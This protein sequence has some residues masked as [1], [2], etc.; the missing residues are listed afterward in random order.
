ML[1]RE[2]RKTGPGRVGAMLAAT[3]AV[4]MI[5]GCSGMNPFYSDNSPLPLPPPLEADADGVVPD[6]TGR[7]DGG[8]GGS[9]DAASETGQADT[10]QNEDYPDLADVPEGDAATRAAEKAPAA[11]AQREELAGELVADREQAKYTDEALRGGK[12]AAMA[13]PRP[14][15]PAPARPAQEA[16]PVTPPPAAPAPAVAPPPVQRTAPR[17]VAPAP[18]A[19]APAA[20]PVATAPVT[21]LAPRAAPVPAAPVQTARAYGSS[22]F[23]PSAAQPLPADLAASLPAGV[24]QR[25]QETLRKPL[26]GIP[27]ALPVT[28]VLSGRGG[29]AFATIPFASG[30][31]QLSGNDRQTLAQVARAASN[32]FGMVRVVGHASSSAAGQPESQR[33]IANW[34]ISQARATAVADELVRQGV[35]AA[36]IIIEAVGDSQ[37]GASAGYADAESAA[38]RVDLF[39]E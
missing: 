34:E 15:T 2:G 26:P 10:A 21:P 1:D 18:V 4:L 33:M 27:A 35:D 25:Y 5:A 30:S 31:S 12:V 3:L 29:G 20:S 28:P 17:P 39:L 16:A 37:S 11:A 14:A 13:S 36:R 19:S 32:G 7:K 23:Q 9:T 6:K 8:D 24:A 22:G 38:R